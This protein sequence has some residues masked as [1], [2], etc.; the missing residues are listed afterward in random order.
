MRSLALSPYL[1]IGGEMVQGQQLQPT[2]VW[3]IYAI[4][5]AM[6]IF[7]VLAMAMKI[8]SGAMK[9]EYIR[10]I[11]PIAEKAAIAK[12]GGEYLPPRE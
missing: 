3:E 1:F 5:P 11:R 7:M 2:A 6:I 4:L 12:A 8:V 9:P 10:E